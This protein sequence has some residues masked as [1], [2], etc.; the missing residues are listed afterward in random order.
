MGSAAPSLLA[1]IRGRCVCV[2]VCVCMCVYE[3]MLFI[4]ALHGVA[5]QRR[6]ESFSARIQSGACV[7]IPGDTRG[8]G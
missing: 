4:D 8:C 3:Y 1:S 6:V 2:C 7:G 5:P